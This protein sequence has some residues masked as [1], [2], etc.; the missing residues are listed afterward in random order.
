[1][2]FIKVHSPDHD[3]YLV[4]VAY[5]ESV[6]PILEDKSLMFLYGYKKC[7]FF[8]CLESVDEIYALIN[9]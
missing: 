1:M 7:F 6:Q 5:I 2:K 8:E 9:A 4:N 3:S